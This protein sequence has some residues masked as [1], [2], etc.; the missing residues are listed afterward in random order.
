DED[1]NIGHAVTRSVMGGFAYSG[2]VCNSVQRIYVHRAR[3]DEFRQQF[4][5]AT[6]KLV[7]GD[8]LDDQTDI[9][10][11]I[12]E[13]AAA[14]ID[15]WVQDAV[16]QGATVAAGGGAPGDAHAT[17]DSGKRQRYDAGNVRRGVWPGGGADVV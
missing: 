7:L 2:Q 4:V 15:Q 16:A 8:P 14:R 6:Q 5:Q 13:A 1:A 9:G 17:D 12:N 10:P 11:V 3:Y